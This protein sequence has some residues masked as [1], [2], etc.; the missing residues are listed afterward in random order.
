MKKEKKN[1]KWLS[2]FLEYIKMLILEIVFLCMCQK[3]VQKKLE[4]FNM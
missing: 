1:L 4:R 3:N 2:F